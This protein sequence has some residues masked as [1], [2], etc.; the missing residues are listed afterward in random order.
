MQGAAIFRTTGELTVAY[1]NDMVQS[2]A[3]GSETVS[4]T[5]DPD[6][7]RIASLTDN[8]TTTINHYAGEGDSPAWTGAGS[9]WTR[10]LTGPGT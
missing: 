4:L 5:L 2:E 1:S 8:T 9:D 6:Q 7:N 10:Y 3:Q